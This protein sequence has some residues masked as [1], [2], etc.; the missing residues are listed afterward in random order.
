MVL[1]GEDGVAATS[2]LGVPVVATAVEPRRIDE[3]A[4]GGRAG[5]RLHVATGTEIRT[6]DLRT[7]ALISVIAA[8][9]VSALTVD[10]SGGQL[11]VG[12]GTAASRPST[13]A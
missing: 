8:P 1:W 6:Y 4:P 12:Y 13:S 11:V 10:E 5:E 9:G 2:D 7:R 3:A